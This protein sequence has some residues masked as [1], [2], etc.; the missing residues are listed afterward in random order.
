[1]YI[2]ICICICMYTC[3]YI[4]IYICIYTYVALAQQRRFEGCPCSQVSLHVKAPKSNAS[5][6]DASCSSSGK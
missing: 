6:A 3:V 4:Y 5:F 1:M 2:H